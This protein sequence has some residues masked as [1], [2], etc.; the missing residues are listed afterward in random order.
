MKRLEM[1]VEDKNIFEE[2][3]FQESKISVCGHKL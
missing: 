2:V 1:I 3:V